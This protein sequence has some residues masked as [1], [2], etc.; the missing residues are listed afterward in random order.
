MILSTLG[1]LASPLAGLLSAPILAQVLGVED[2]GVVG[3][4]TAPLLLAMSMVTLG[5]PEAMTYYIAGKNS[6]VR[7]TLIKG[8]GYLAAAGTLMTA[9]IICM[10]VA[11]AGGRADLST[12]IAIAVVALV[13][14][15]LLM[16]TRAIAA[17][18]GLWGL[19]AIEKLVG[20]ALRL[21][22][23]SVLA[24]MGS[25]NTT[26]ATISIA[27]TTFIGILAYAS[28]PWVIRRHQVPMSGRS[29]NTAGML[30]FGM[31]MWIGALTG[32]LL[33]RL[34]Q[35]LMTPL[36]SVYQM[37][38]YV[39]AVSVSEIVQVFNGAVRD[40]VFSAESETQMDHR[41]T[42][43]SRTSTL[44]TLAAAI[45]VGLSSI[46][47]LPILFG[48]EFAE[49]VVILELLLIGTVLGNPGSVAGVGLTARGRPGLRSWSLGVAFIVNVTLTIILV[50]KFGALGAAVATLIGSVVAG[51][52]NIVWLRVFF[53]IPARE[54]L[55]IRAG[56]AEY[57]LKMA[58]NILRNNR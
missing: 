10:S 36:S 27:G 31:R 55:H 45:V 40:V 14:S 7:R 13:P 6:S 32:I 57:L 50:P 3:A 20:A 33:A 48:Y 29:N 2:R 9:L 25:L 12:L 1:N 4:A 5:L 11:L 38:L 49:S 22:S 30:A 44:V 53:H 41:L 21:T 46:W 35:T 18:L 52:L 56:D 58:K 54:F 8:F 24:L 47:L 16:A 42:L 19:I 28:M 17:G 26:T 23:V 39:V 43:A 34:D 51:G 37:G 15:L